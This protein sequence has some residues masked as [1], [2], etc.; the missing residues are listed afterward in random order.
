MATRIFRIRSKREWDLLSGGQSYF[1][2]ALWFRHAID[3]IHIDDPI[4]L[5]F[6]I[7]RK[8]GNAVTRNK[9]KRRIREVITKNEANSQ[10]PSGLVILVG[11]QKNCDKPIKYKTINDDVSAFISWLK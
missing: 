10:F 5:G 4:K 8:Y 6:A 1:S 11:T 2:Q 7:S 3:E 9:L